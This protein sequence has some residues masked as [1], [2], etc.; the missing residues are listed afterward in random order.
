MRLSA[1]LARYM[2]RQFLFGFLAVFLLLSTVAFVVDFV[3][4]LRRS[5]AKPDV[6]FSVVLDMSLLKLPFLSGHMTVF[7]VLFGA[8]IAFTRLSRSREL[9]VVR[10]AGVS[11]WQFLAP[12]LAIAFAI[13]LFKIVVLNP[14][15]AATL[16][17]FEQVEN[18][19]LKGRASILAVSPS[20]VWL[21]QADR[22]GQSVVHARQ[23]ASRE[24]EMYDFIIFLYDAQ[25]RFTGR[26]DAAKAR[27]ESGYWHLDE[28]WLTG[29]DRPAK[30]ENEYTVRTDLT[31]AKI[32]ES[33]SSP[34]T[35]AF[36][37]LPRFI[38]VLEQ[39]GFSG[40]RHRIHFNAL[41]ADPILMC[42]MVLF[43]A[44]FTLQRN[45]R[46]G[47]GVL[48]AAGALATVVVLYFLSDVVF[49]LGA[50]ASI[51]AI[52][53]A[54]SPAGASLLVGASILIYTEER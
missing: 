8:M 19:Y 24:M 45:L 25:N 31:A 23:V 41:V 9:I 10:S 32:Q 11:A 17:K 13:G 6:T 12:I 16:S 22:S 30:F 18:K 15:A 14:I 54:W 4:V 43:A 51:P 34:A 50:S 47:G 21:R 39:A 27:L 1:T 7:S 28:A 48:M 53:A 37:D 33:F 52:L 36:W 49:A 35:V 2:G 38:R 46:R 5:A 20:G 3:E 26:I 42:A 44:T 29:P 40:L